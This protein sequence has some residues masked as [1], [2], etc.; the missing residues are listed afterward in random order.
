M[1]WGISIITTIENGHFFLRDSAAAAA[2]AHDFL[3]DQKIRF[4]SKANAAFLPRSAA[5]LSR[6]ICLLVF[7][8]GEL[9]ILVRHSVSKSPKMSH[10]NFRAKKTILSIMARN[11]LKKFADGKMRLFEQ[12]YHY[13]D[14]FWGFLRIVGN[15]KM[16]VVIADLAWLNGPNRTRG[17]VWWN[18]LKTLPRLS[19]KKRHLTRCFENA[20]LP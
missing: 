20:A 18:L 4:T 15:K 16:V 8:E 1:T 12:F 17:Y 2:A 7:I 6:C 3:W 9:L 19:C 13:C 11:S 14:F 5:Q 10:L